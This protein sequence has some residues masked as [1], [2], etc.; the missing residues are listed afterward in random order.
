[1]KRNWQDKRIINATVE[2]SNDNCILDKHIIEGI[3]DSIYELI[4][5]ENKSVMD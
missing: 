2:I 1:M 5:Y 4:E 3:F